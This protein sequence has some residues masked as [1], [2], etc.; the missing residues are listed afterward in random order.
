MKSQRCI[1]CTIL[2]SLVVMLAA[3]AATLAMRRL[4]HRR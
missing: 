1:P 3:T 4:L 2:G